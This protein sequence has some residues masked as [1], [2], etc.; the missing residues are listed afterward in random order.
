MRTEAT[1][2]REVTWTNLDAISEDQLLW[3]SSTSDYGDDD[4]ADMQS[5]A[6]V[7]RAVREVL[8]PKQREV[9]EAYFFAGL[10]QGEIAR[11]LGISQQVVHKRIFGVEVNGRRVG[12]ALRKLR[13]A[14]T[15]SRAVR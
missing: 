7:R 15:P 1:S 13:I 12:G 3:L 11:R 2:R 8:R 4:D 14:L 6:D 10:S 9:V 5:D